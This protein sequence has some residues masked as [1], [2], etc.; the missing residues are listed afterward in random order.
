MGKVWLVEH[1][2]FN[3]INEKL[4]ADI[5]QKLLD[6]IISSYEENSAVYVTYDNN[7]LGWQVIPIEAKSNHNDNDMF[8][9]FLNSRNYEYMGVLK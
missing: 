6:H 3:N 9:D 2:N 5:S 4:G 1:K 8:I 7:H